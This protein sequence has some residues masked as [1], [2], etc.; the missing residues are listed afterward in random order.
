MDRMRRKLARPRGDGYESGIPAKFVTGETPYFRLLYIFRLLSRIFRGMLSHGKY[1][2]ANIKT[3]QMRIRRRKLPLSLSLSLSLSFSGE[4]R[5]SCLQPTRLRFRSVA[6][7][8]TFSS[9]SFAFSSLCPFRGILSSRCPIRVALCRAAPVS[10]CVSARART[11]GIFRHACNL[12]HVANTCYRF[13]VRLH[14]EFWTIVRA[15][16]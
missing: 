15:S 2:N 14:V 5:S 3:R 16:V 4:G 11:S 8:L 13:R 1:T 6:L 9:F 7:V 12:A 10:V